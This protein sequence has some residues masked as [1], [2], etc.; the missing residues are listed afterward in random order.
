MKPTCSSC[1]RPTTAGE[2]DNRFY[3]PACGRLVDSENG[4]CDRCN[5]SDEAKK[6]GSY[7]FKPTITINPDQSVGM[8]QGWT[9]CVLPAGEWINR[10]LNAEEYVRKA[11]IAEAKSAIITDTFSDKRGEIV[12]L[13]LAGKKLNLLFSKAGTY[14]A[15]D[16]HPCTQ[17]NFIIE[18]EV[19]VTRQYP[20]S[21]EK[22]NTF[23]T[24]EYFSTSAGVPH[25]FC[26]LADTWMVE[27]WDD[28]FEA[29]YFPRYRKIVEESLK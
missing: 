21:L 29:T 1:G 26:F 22:E 8:H 20:D 18:G 24:G 5:A 23:C 17:R 12:K 6:P 9:A 19:I 11:E 13:L 10:A 27:L 4:V 2:P 14:R 15:G 7:A 3:C 25:L 28:E 16:F